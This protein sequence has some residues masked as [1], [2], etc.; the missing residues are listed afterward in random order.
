MTSSSS[1]ET[2][3]EPWPRAMRRVTCPV[4]QIRGRKTHTMASRGRATC[5]ASP[6]L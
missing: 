2:P 3:G 1:S 5:P 4:S 6:R